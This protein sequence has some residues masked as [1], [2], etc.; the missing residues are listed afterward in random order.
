MF[1]LIHEQFIKWIP[2]LPNL[3]ECIISA[4]V[5]QIYRIFLIFIDFHFL[6]VLR[7]FN[8]LI[9]IENF[10]EFICILSH[11]RQK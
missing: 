1:Q 8:D 9:E 6:E 7:V 5:C 11:L 10:V 2:P 3:V 4:G